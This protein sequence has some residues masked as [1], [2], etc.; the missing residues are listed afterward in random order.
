ME[1]SGRGDTNDNIIHSLNANTT[2]KTIVFGAAFK[3]AWKFSFTSFNLI[4]FI[5]GKCARNSF[6]CHF[7]NRSLSRSRIHC[8]E[9][10][11]KDVLF[12]LKMFCF[13]FNECFNLNVYVIPME[14]TV[15][16]KIETS[17]T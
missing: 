11:L 8:S 6:L 3:C 10:F 9:F 15:K 1:W 13:Q 5:V 7:F 4:F 14:R 2:G 12:V 16:R 17:N